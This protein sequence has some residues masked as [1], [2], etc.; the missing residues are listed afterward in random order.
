[1]TEHNGSS[2]VDFVYIV[3]PAPRSLN[4][5][6]HKISTTCI[7]LR[8]ESRVP[9]RH[10]FISVTHPTGVL[11]CSPEV[12][13]AQHLASVLRQITET[14]QY[15]GAH[16]NLLTTCGRIEV[17]DIQNRLRVWK[18]TPLAEWCCVEAVK[19]QPY[20]VRKTAPR[21]QHSFVDY[22]KTGTQEFS[23]I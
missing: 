22:D 19:N 1:M 2:V 11:C 15:G 3:R 13:P 16:R 14:K 9:E 10:T 8:T 17:R 6:Q 12:L 21:N 7:F 20:V 5:T 4:F 18:N 23:Y